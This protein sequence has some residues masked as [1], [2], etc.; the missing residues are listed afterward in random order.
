MLRPLLQVDIQIL[1]RILIVHVLRHVKVDAADKIDRLF[2][3]LQID[4]H[5]A[6]DRKAEQAVQARGKPFHAVRTAARVNR[7]D[8]HKSPAPGR[9]RG[10]APGI[11]RS[12]TVCVFASR[13]G[14]DDGVG[15]VAIAVGAADENVI[16]AVAQRLGLLGGHV[17][18]RLLLRLKL[19]RCDWNGGRLRRFFLGGRLRLGE[20][21]T[22][23][24]LHQQLPRRKTRF[25]RLPARSPPRSAP[26]VYRAAARTFLYA[27]HGGDCQIAS[28]RVPFGFG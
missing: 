28:F 23:H 26:C 3:R 19:L 1:R 21:R 13:W 14:D 9:D 5:I 18:L 17:L 24:R 22:L 11:D 15:A 7:V 8:L 27:P 16:H 12:A 6:V 10:I 25:R 2:E 4:E 20:R